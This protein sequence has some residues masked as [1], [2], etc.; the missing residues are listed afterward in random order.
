MIIDLRSDL[1][2]FRDYVS[3]LIDEHVRKGGPKP[4]MIHFGFTFDQDGWVNAYLDTRPNASRDG[5]WTTHLQPRTLLLRP[6]WYDASELSNLRD[7]VLIGTNGNELQEWA[8]NPTLQNLA[9]ILGEFLRSSVS[10]FEAE[11]LFQPL[12]EPQKLNYS[13]EE[14]TG[15]YGWP[16]DPNVAKFVESLELSGHEQQRRLGC[17]NFAGLSG[18]TSIYSRFA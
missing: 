16:I 4:G 14:F 18:F 13:V 15:L 5:E 9:N 17:E 3:R 12:L 6:H 2:D 1:A 10:T 7:L 8:A 11:G